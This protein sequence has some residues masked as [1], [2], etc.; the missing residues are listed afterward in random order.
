MEQFQKMITQRQLARMQIGGRRGSINYSSPRSGGTVGYTGKFSSVDDESDS[1]SVADSQKTVNKSSRR[2]NQREKGKNIRSKFEKGIKKSK[3]MVG[4]FTTRNASR[5]N[6]IEGNK[7][8]RKFTFKSYH[9]SDGEE[10]SEENEVDSQKVLVDLFGE[11]IVANN[12]YKHRRRAFKKGEN[13]SAKEGYKNQKE[14]NAP[15]TGNLVFDY[16]WGLI[17]CCNSK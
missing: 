7:K 14:V 5:K 8:Q 11:Q 12:T 10:D 3:L 17:G 2:R 15:K 16:L 6:K 9:Q 1:M 4:G 13:D